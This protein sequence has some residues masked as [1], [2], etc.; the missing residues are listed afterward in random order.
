MK[1]LNILIFV[2]NKEY[3]RALAR[4]LCNEST[5]LNV[6]FEEEDMDVALARNWDILLTDCYSQESPK[7]LH[8]SEENG[9]EGLRPSISK[10]SSVRGI[11]SQISA[12]AKANYGLTPDC[13]WQSDAKLVSLI[14]QE[15]G[16][17]LT[18]IAITLA[19]LLS[20]KGC[21]VLYLNLGPMDDYKSYIA[22]DF[23]SIGDK[24]QFYFLKEE[25]ISGSVERFVAQDRWGVSYFRPEESK[26]SYFNEVDNG[27]LI[28]YL[29]EEDVFSHM[30]IDYGKGM[31]QDKKEN[32]ILINIRKNPNRVLSND[33]VEIDLELM[34][35]C[36]DY[37]LESAKNPI[38]ADYEAFIQTEENIEISM[39]SEFSQRVEDFIL[40]NESLLL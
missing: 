27:R 15:G 8:L 14:T 38:P 21:R 3:G 18:S 13:N 36:D 28:R 29:E 22:A 17:G 39:S 9:H 10:R 19:R 26:N 5:S 34:N 35:F 31:I 2:R 24:R 40:E 20:A 16:S 30:V 25:G 32:E 7:I 37:C 23:Y 11:F 4:G 33:L 12:M 6:F 1:P